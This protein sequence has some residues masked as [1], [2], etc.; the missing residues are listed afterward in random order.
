M[1]FIAVLFSI[2]LCNAVSMGHGFD[3]GH[4]NYEQ[5][6]RLLDAIPRIKNNTGRY[7]LK[8]ELNGLGKNIQDVSISLGGCEEFSV[9]SGTSTS[10]DGLTT[11][12]YTGSAGVS[13]G[14][15]MTGLYILYDSRSN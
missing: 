9:L 11:R 14:T 2:A 8:H 12:I 1:I 15:A 3:F 6:G 5:S 10:F 7:L 4:G 13:P